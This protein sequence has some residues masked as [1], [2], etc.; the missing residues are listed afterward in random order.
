[1]KTMKN[2]YN[3]TCYADLEREEIRVRKR[4]KRQEV[5]LQE[6]I[7]RLPEEVITIGITKAITGIISGNLMKTASSV[8]KGVV[9]YFFGKSDNSGG[10]FFKRIF[11]EE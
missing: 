11:G 7:K 9:S 8:F 5:E 1:M 2:N 4:I 6:R 10:G 3:I